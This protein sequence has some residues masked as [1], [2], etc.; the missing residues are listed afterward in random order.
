M[1][2]MKLSRTERR[3]R[4]AKTAKLYGIKGENG[5]VVHHAYQALFEKDLEKTMKLIVP[6]S[7]SD[8]KNKHPWIILGGAALEKVEGATAKVFFELAREIAPKD[9]VILGGIAKAHVLEAEIE[10][11]VR[12]MEL[13]F[14]AGNTDRG[15]V[16][17]F[18][19]LMSRM[20]R[21]PKAVDIVSPVV[22]NLNDAELCFRLGSLLSDADET[23][24]AVP[25]LERAFQLDPK[26]EAHQVGRLHGLLYS[27]RF[28]EVETAALELLETVENRDNVMVLYLMALR[29]LGD[30]DKT[31]ELVDSFEFTDPKAFAL[32]RGIM[33]NVY[34]DQEQWD[35]VESA[36]IEAMHI[37]GEP[38]KIAKA[39]GVYK[40]REQDFADGF[41]YYSDR[42]PAQNRKTIPLQN[43]APEN[44]AKLERIHLMGE[45]GIGD[46]LALL[47]LLRIAPI[48]LEKTE[49]IYISD[50][51][52][53]PVLQDNRLNISFISQDR[54]F[55]EPRNLQANELVYLGDLS[56]YLATEP[57]AAITGAYLKPN[58]NRVAHFKNKYQAKAN[59]RPIVGVAW[60]SASLTGH[61]RSLPLLEL[62]KTI[63]EGALVVN[64]QYNANYEEIRSAQIRRP[65][66]EIL[67]DRE[68][69]Q[70][71]D[72]DGFAAQIVALDHVVTI[73]NTTAHFC[74]ALG[75]ED[76]HV[77]IPL[78]SECMWYWGRAGSVDPWYGNLNLHRQ[79][80][81]RDWAGPIDSVVRHFVSK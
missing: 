3:A 13:A 23:N 71:T 31:T 30:Y 49:V 76:T 39:L 75:H 58:E 36:Y 60:N 21:N 1:Q 80:Q 54:F 2:T 45:Q 15:L 72:L 32:A 43:A 16:V 74:G 62:L 68:V 69:D 8:P 66:L 12:M 38:G 52:L 17:L 9:P 65:D 18:L 56:Q 10:P 67:V 40:Y 37:A 78:G 24:A 28:K 6:I 22:K 51:R 44:L 73:D 5:L 55:S 50:A 57:L 20:G 53:K 34:Q 35:D 25:W 27:R 7:R 19:E 48:D 63:K 79:T 59:G 81:L 64:L 14:A 47:S 33:A 42:F 4:F 61:M 11:A 77:F 29:L 70:A 41:P 26:S 46:Q